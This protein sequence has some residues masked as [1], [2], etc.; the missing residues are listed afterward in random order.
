MMNFNLLKYWNPIFI[1]TGTFHGNAVKAALSARFKKIYS[2]ELK[3]E[4]YN[5]CKYKFRKEIKK[6]KV[7][8]FLGDSS[9]CLPKI[10]EEVSQNATF[11]LDAHYSSGNTARGPVDVPLMMELD[12]ISKHTVKNHTILID[13]VRL[14]DSKGAED[15]TNVSLD[16]VI[17]TLKKINP[18]Y[19][20]SYEKGFCKNDI[21][22]AQISRYRFLK[23]LGRIEEI[24]FFPIKKILYV[25]RKI[26][27][28]LREALKP[29]CKRWG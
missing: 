19:S 11:W 6:G 8:L 5:E 14:F 9:T 7:K 10:L 27:T 23:I 17:K 4:F 24:I 22:V 12:A 13:D 28:T 1:E 18:N 3:E 29:Y 16:S 21:L 15:W 2:I 20:I 26:K 25:L